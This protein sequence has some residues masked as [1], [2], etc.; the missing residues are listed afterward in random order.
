[1]KTLGCALGLI[2]FSTLIMAAP[3]EGLK[4]QQWMNRL[5]LYTVDAEGMSYLGRD[6]LR[7]LE[8]LEER[9]LLLV[10]LGDGGTKSLPRHLALDAAAIHSL[11]EQLGADVGRTE[12]ILIGKDGT[13]KE[14][15]ERI[16]FAH[17]FAV[18]DG[19]PMRRAERRRAEH[20]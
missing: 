5:I 17:L 16:D 4:H 6:V 1:M 14:R 15:I 2:L 13:V 11:V 7:H 19:M 9:D 18:I 20:P 10:H 3:F 12:L 8:A